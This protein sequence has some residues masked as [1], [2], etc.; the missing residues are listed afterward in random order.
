M[1]FERGFIVKNRPTGD[2][3]Y[4]QQM[5]RR[6]VLD[7]LL[8]HGPMSKIEI[9]RATTLSPTTVGNAIIELQAENLVH[10]VG[11]VAS[12]LGRRPTLLDIQWNSRSVIGLAII[13]N[14]VIGV[15]TNIAAVV[16]KV[17]IKKFELSGNIIAVLTAIVDELMEGL[18][19]TSVLGIG[20]A[21][22]GILNRKDGEIETI[23]NYPWKH[24]KFPG[25][26]LHH[27]SLPWVIE[28]DT[29]A[30]ALG[31]AY[32]GR[33]R[34]VQSFCYVHVGTGIGAGIIVDHHIFLGSHG[35]AGEVG[36]I[37]VET[38]GKK[39]RCGNVGCL[40]AHVSWQEVMS[41]LRD[42]LP[43][44]MWVD[45]FETIVDRA[46][47]LRSIYHKGM[48]SEALVD[49]ADMLAVG[50]SSLV[51]ITDPSLVIVEGIFNQCS[52]FMNV[53]QEYTNRRLINLSHGAPLVTTGELSEFASVA[54]IIVVLLEKYGF[55]KSPE[56][57]LTAPYQF[58]MPVVIEEIEAK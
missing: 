58:K 5:N 27:R 17:S 8:N 9:S 30:A 44:E 22:P 54:G 16:Q 6:L 55:L 7:T 45:D 37:T 1:V 38:K 42:H 28:N 35:N 2:L 10:E 39:C 19:D 57:L 4:V 29:N 40:E 36:H 13:D 21:T 32:F 56:S 46:G 33:G 50:I 24:L 51:S 47:Y 52:E 26:V 41:L 48:V 49:I 23:A 53:L 20:L 25:D 11:K 43:Q 31:E 12:P 18:G 15:R 34:G 3:Q 14:K